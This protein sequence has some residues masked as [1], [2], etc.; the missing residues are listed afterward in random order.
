MK[1]MKNST[2]IIPC[3]LFY[4]FSLLLLLV[5]LL[6]VIMVIDRNAGMIHWLPVQNDP[7]KL[8]DRFHSDPTTSQMC[9]LALDGPGVGK[10]EQS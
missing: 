4:Y 2:N 9:I 10:G 5:L 3:T 7:F 1:V 8:C 6:F